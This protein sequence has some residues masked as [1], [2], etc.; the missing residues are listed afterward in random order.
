[1]SLSRLPALPLIPENENPTRAIQYPLCIV[2]DH[3]RRPADFLDSI[4][5]HW[6]RILI[7][8]H[9]KPNDDYGALLTRPGLPRGDR[10]HC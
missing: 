5:A 2:G 6:R 9:A 8:Q 10:F 1:M 4:E 7:G 3:F